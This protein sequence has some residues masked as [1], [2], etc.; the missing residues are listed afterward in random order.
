MQRR[1]GT[2][3]KMMTMLLSLTLSLF[4]AFQ[5]RAE[6]PVQPD[7]DAA[8]FSGM[9]HIMAAVSNCPI[10][11]SMKDLMK[12]SAAIITVTPEDNL[13]FK[14]GFPLQDGCKKIDL[15]F[16][17]T[18]QLGHYTNSQMGKQDMRVVA[19]DYTNYAIVYTFK[20]DDGKS[21]T[22]LQLYSRIQEVN[23]EAMK[24][25][26]ELYPP[27]GLT[28]NMLVILPKSD[29]CVKALSS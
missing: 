28:D 8:K 21:S 22:T 13:R 1:E 2:V 19:T 3:V 29:E 10:F 20:D 5:A 24:I 25:F 11:Q 15:V 16:E 7:F 14:I 18:G 12:T 27:M 26:K 23:P 4:G 9:W 17:K 6:V